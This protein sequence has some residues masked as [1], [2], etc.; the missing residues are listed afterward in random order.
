MCMCIRLIK[1]S[2]IKQMHE[3]S[4]SQL[5]CIAFAMSRMHLCDKRACS[6]SV[7]LHSVCVILRTQMSVDIWAASGPSAQQKS[8]AAPARPNSVH[9]AWGGGGSGVGCSS[10]RT[11]AAEQA[12]AEVCRRTARPDSAPCRWK[13]MKLFF[14]SLCL[15]CHDCMY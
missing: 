3:S 13:N 2:L 1:S 8:F 5:S 9:N 15:P 4:A 7:S 10:P 6:F 11:R 14:P 12:Q